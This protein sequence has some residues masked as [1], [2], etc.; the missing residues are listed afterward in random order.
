MR[1]TLTG[2]VVC[3]LLAGLVAVVGPAAAKQRSHSASKSGP[4]AHAAYSNLVR[5][6]GASNCKIGRYGADPC[7]RKRPYGVL[8]GKYVRI[9][10][11]GSGGKEIKF[12][13]YS[14]GTGKRL[15]TRT[16]NAGDRKTIW[17]NH[18]HHR[19]N[20][21]FTADASGLVNTVATGKFLFGPY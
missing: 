5:R 7:G 15:G 1:K 21:R 12:R 19:V 20:I 11:Q 18:T 4:Q 13:A 17:T 8:G 9:A 6:F 3:G 2:A 14:V 16:M 10:L